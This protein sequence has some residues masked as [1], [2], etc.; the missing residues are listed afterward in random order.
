MFNSDMKKLY[1]RF[2]TLGVLLGVLLLLTVPRGVKAVNCTTCDWA[3]DVCL[4]GC[5]PTGHVAPLCSNCEEQWDQ[6]EMDCTDCSQCEGNYT[7]CQNNCTTQADTCL[8]NCASN[9][10]ACQ[11]ACHNTENSCDSTCFSNYQSCED[12]CV[13]G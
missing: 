6:C 9:D 11:D 10:T 4:N 2:L 3:L 12:P 13:G 1:K 8:Q 5:D 7:A